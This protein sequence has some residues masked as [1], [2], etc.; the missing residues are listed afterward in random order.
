MGVR[1]FFHRADFKTQ[2][3]SC[4]PRLREDDGEGWGRS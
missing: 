4:R 3:Y 1:R 2:S